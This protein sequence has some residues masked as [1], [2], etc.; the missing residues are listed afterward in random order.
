MRVYGIWGNGAD[1]FI[2][3]AEVEKQMWKVDL[4]TWGEGEMY[5]RSNMET[6]ITM[7]KTDSQWKFAV[8]P[9]KLKQGLRINLDEWDGEGDVR[10]VQK[11]GENNPRKF[12]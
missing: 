2:C 3:G 6:C 4:W 1:E 7:C 8:W 10:E 11:G 12:T 5:G 9:R